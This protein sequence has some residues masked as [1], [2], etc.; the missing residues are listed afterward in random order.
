MLLLLFIIFTFGHL[1]ISQYQGNEVFF[2]FDAFY[3]STY[4]TITLS[5]RR[6]KFVEILSGSL[7]VTFM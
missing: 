3:S 7:A 6:N 2:I 5:V 4:F 1:F